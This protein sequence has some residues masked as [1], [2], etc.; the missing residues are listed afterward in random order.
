ML[1]L[2]E[3]K[4]LKGGCKFLLLFGTL[5]LYMNS[6][7]RGHIWL[8]SIPLVCLVNSEVWFGSHH[9]HTPIA[10]HIYR[11]AYL[12]L[13]CSD[14]GARTQHRW[15]SKGRIRQNRISRFEGADPAMGMSVYRMP[16][17]IQKFKNRAIKLFSGK[18]TCIL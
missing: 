9:Q 17:K 2:E 14:M 8:F 6:G 7:Y 13:S 1:L 3:V 18:L 4:I 15:G 16:K 10:G 12:I 5:Q 11:K